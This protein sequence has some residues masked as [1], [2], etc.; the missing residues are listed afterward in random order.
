MRIGERVPPILA[1]LSAVGTLACCLPIGGATMLGLGSVLMVVGRYQQWFLPAA[2]VLLVIGTTHIV[3]SRR[4]CRTTSRVS[5]AILALS[6]AI[7]GL[8]VFFPQT[9]AG[10]LSDFLS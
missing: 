6:A 1:A 3:R 4:K 2:G 5:L 10:L 8:I 7:V 9:I